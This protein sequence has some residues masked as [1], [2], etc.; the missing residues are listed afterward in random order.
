MS[1]SHRAGGAAA[2]VLVLALAGC[3]SE[4]AGAA[5]AEDDAPTGRVISVEIEEARPA[6]FTDVVRIVGHVA[7]HRDVTVSA[8]EGGVIRALLVEKGALVRAGQPIARVDDTVLRAEVDRAAATARLAAE[9]WQ[10]QQR[11][12]EVE[13]VGTE[14]AYLQ[15]RSEAQVAEAGARVLRERLARTTVRAPIAGVLDD[16]F[17]EVGTM[18]APGA[19]VARVVDASTVKIVGGI[20]ERHAAEIGTGAEMRVVFD[21]LAGVE[22]VGKVSFVGATLNES[23]RTFPIEVR[24]PNANRVLRP[25][26]AANLEIARGTMAEALL[27]PQNAVLRR[28]NGY[29]VYVAVERDGEL[30]AELRPVVPGSSRGNRVVITEGVRAGDRVITVGQQQVSEG[31]RLRIVD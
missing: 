22:H 11:L 24:V 13:K 2:A 29:V 28:E 20:P 3:A 17:V 19:P 9:V 5:I 14:M 26:M 1:V 18:V 16:R 31:D 15:A 4:E 21:A 12:W 8:E 6:E 30:V 10:R 7:A 23:N 25:G 27:V